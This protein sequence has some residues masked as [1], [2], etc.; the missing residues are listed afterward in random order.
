MPKATV[1]GFP[2]WVLRSVRQPPETR[3]ELLHVTIGLGQCIGRRFAVDVM[4]VPVSHAPF[5]AG[6]SL[7]S[8]GRRSASFTA[9][10]RSAETKSSTVHGRGSRSFDTRTPRS[11]KASTA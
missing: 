3:D 2:N 11:A 9:I 7:R 6:K 4:D 5:P 8:S 1:N 10:A